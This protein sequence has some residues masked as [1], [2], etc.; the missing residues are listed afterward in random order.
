MQTKTILSLLAVAALTTTQPMKAENYT[1][2]PDEHGMVLKTPDGRTMFR[3]M[4]RKPAQTPLTANS[5]CCLFPVNTPSGEG[6]VDFAPND[7]PHHRG[8]FLA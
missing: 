2:V 4:T 5:V 8:V 1:L 7:H 3:Y 6:V